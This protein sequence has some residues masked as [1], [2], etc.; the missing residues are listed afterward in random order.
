MEKQQRFLFHHHLKIKA[1]GEEEDDVSLFST[2]FAGVG[3]A[4]RT[5]DISPTFFL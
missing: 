2:R 5:A 3:R 4:V 1:D